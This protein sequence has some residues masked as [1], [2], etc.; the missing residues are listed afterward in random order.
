MRKLVLVV[1]GPS[2]AGKTT[3]IEALAVPDGSHYVTSQPMVDD[4]KRR[5]LP[6]DHD[7]I[8]ALSQEWYVQ[9]QYWQVPLIA[10]ALE[11]RTFVVVDGPRRLP[12]VL[13]LKEMGLK[14]IVVSVT[15]PPANRFGRL[16]KRR[17]ITL[18]T[19]AEFDRL[20]TDEAQTMDVG[21]LVNLAEV[22]VRNVGGEA[23]H[24]Q[25]GR[26]VGKIIRYGNFLPKTLL[27]MTLR[28]AVR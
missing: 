28:A 15:S 3:F 7:T 24:R 23:D 11:G 25:K 9:D 20:E 8:F 27:V 21:E 26:L 6:V 19:L 13:R 2:G 4:L 12:E 17:K 10:R 16:K 22:V 14:V 1:V 18:Q 5:G